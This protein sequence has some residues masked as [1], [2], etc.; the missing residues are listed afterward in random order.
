MD[1]SVIIV[2]WNT[3]ALLLQCIRSI[4]DTTDPAPE[5]I[6]VDNASEDNSA[7]AVNESFPQVKVIRNDKNLGFSGAN[8][9]GIRESSGKYVCFINS[10]VIVL[11]D[12][13]GRMHA[14]M[15]ANPDIGILG[16]KVL[17]PDGKTVQ[18]SC[19]G[20]PTLWN[21]LCRAVGIDSLFPKVRL[22]GG[23]LMTFWPHDT[24]R[25]VD[26][27]NGCFWMIR[28]S[29]IE[30]VGMLDENF[31]MYAEDVDWCKRFHDWGWKNVFYP[32]AEAVHYGGASSA[33]MPVRFYVEKQRANFQ[34]WKKHHDRFS[35]AIYSSTLILHESSRALIYSLLYWDKGGPAHLLPRFKARRSIECLR[36]LTR[37][38]FQTNK[39]RQ[40]EKALL[41]KG[42]EISC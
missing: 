11:K 10:D 27:I 34:Y 41:P 31:F 18:R 20:F 22:F 7:D 3:R 28:R 30:Q 2:S 35:T 14:Y 32:D 8:N 38:M 33:A 5:I 40:S 9:I 4:I 37:I 39:P 24:L 21:M 1:I 25:E 16:P 6:V 19:M 17:W 13:I 36:L 12:C 15:E 23:H 29:G 42:G 26:V